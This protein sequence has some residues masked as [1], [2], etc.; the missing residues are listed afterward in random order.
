MTIGRKLPKSASSLGPGDR[1]GRRP[2]ARK[3]ARTVT[4]ACDLPLRQGESLREGGQHEPM[5]SSGESRMRNSIRGLPCRSTRGGTDRGLQGFELNHR[6][7]R[8]RPSPPSRP[9]SRLSRRRQHRHRLGTSPP[10]RSPTATPP[11]TPV[12][13]PATISGNWTGTVQYFDL[14]YWWPHCTSGA[15]ATFGQGPPVYGSLVSASI[16]TNCVDASFQGTLQDDGTLTGEVTVKLGDLRGAASGSFWEAP[17]FSKCRSSRAPTG[18][19]SGASQSGCSDDPHRRAAPNVDKEGRGPLRLHTLPRRIVRDKEVLMN[20]F[21]TESRRR[22]GRQL[23][24]GLAFIL[25]AATTAGAQSYS[26][27]DV[28]GATD[29]SPFGINDRGDVVGR[30][31]DSDFNTMDSCSATETSRRSTSRGAIFTAPRFVNNLGHVAGR[32]V[33]ADGVPRGFVLKNGKFTTIDAPGAVDMR[34]AR[35]TT[36]AG[37][38][39]TTPK[40]TASSTA[41]SSTTRGLS[42]DRRSRIQL[43]RRLADQRPRPHGRR[44]HGLGRPRSRLHAEERPFHADRLSRP[45]RDLDPWN[46]PP[47]HLSRAHTRPTTAARSASSSDREAP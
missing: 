36:S 1:T 46:R 12:P 6:T 19:R 25:L 7:C 40:T 5:R 23:L 13:T 32:Y 4:K 27:I 44:L 34:G 30:W 20:T 28:P 39:A 29:T 21:G 8:R 14:D 37:S 35:S 2:R 16:H 47:G 45:V 10:T 17:S 22:R 43:D 18:A 24:V 38:R 41:S 11:A 26:S 42:H 33:D 9:P 3:T 15:T 31:D